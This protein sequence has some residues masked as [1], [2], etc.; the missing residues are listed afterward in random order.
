MTCPDC[1]GIA[2]A[3]DGAT[4]RARRLAGDVDRVSRA[5]AYALDVIASKDDEIERLRAAIERLERAD[6][7]RRYR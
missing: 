3:Y 7:E 4:K 2:K 1:A 5:N 6:K